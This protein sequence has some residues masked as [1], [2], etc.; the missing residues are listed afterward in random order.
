MDLQR[1]M[2]RFQLTANRL[3]ESWMDL[4]PDLDIQ[5]PEVIAAILQRRTAH[6]EQQ[7]NLVGIAAATPGAQPHVVVPWTD[8]S[9]LIFVSLADLTQDQRNT[10]TSIMTHRGRTLAEYTVQE[11]RDL[12]LEMF[13]ATRTAVDNPMMQPSGMAQRRSFL[14]MDEGESE[15][16]GTTGYWA[17]DDEDGAEGF[18]EALD[19]VFWVYDDN[20]YTWYQRRFQGRSTRR[21]KGGK[22][23]MRKGRGKGRSGRR[24]FRPRR[25]GKGKGRRKGRSHMVGEE[26]YEEDWQEEEEW[27][28]II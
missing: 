5:S 24:F 13:C 28:E 1:W 2:T 14:V 17:E 11:L 12:F 6:D 7:Q 16:D 18:L 20:V 9:A 3:I 4:I 15:I 23:K 25:K 19:D 27:N 8:L 22:N 10:L 26:G 21:G